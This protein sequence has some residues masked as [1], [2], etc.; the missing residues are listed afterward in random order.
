[1]VLVV[2][3]LRALFFFIA[4]SEGDGHAEVLFI[5][6]VAYAP[7]A[8]LLYVLDELPGLVLVAAF[9]YI[10]L[11]WAEIAHN[12]LDEKELFEGSVK[13]AALWFMAAI[14]L[15]Q[16]LA[17]ILYG[18]T[19]KGTLIWSLITALLHALTFLAAS[20]A[21]VVYGMRLRLLLVETPV[22]LLL[23]LGKATEIVA[24]TALVATCLFVRACAILVASI[25]A[26]ARQGHPDERPGW[27]SAVGTVLGYAALEVLPAAALL[28]AQRQRLRGAGGYLRAMREQS[29]RL[30]VA[31]LR[32][33]KRKAG[34]GASGG[35][36]A[37]GAPKATR[38]AGVLGEKGTESGPGSGRANDKHG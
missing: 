37:A 16:L 27:G 13:P 32:G 1:M 25:W 28:Y 33:S 26:V 9:A 35:Q 20:V 38:G 29:E 2:S 8:H 21:F 17:W 12:F 31:A 23:R 11:Q 18:E 3:T 19:L 34:I 24:M 6:M 14:G 36:A 10:V 22:A 7:E 30:R 4:P 5:R 15:L